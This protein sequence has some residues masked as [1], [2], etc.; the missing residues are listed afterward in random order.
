[1]KTYKYKRQSAHEMDVIITTNNSGDML[2]IYT[3]RN[4]CDDFHV[5]FS[6]NGMTTNFRHIRGECMIITPTIILE[7]ECDDAYNNLGY[8]IGTLR[9]LTG[10]Y[11]FLSFRKFLGFI[12]PDS[13]N[14]SM[15]LYKIDEIGGGKALIE[16]VLIN[17]IVD[18]II[19]VEYKYGWAKYSLCSKDYCITIR[20]Y[21]AVLYVFTDIETFGSSFRSKLEARTKRHVYEKK[22][23]QSN[24]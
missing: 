22:F 13:F 1:M 2:S 6:R 24:I 8:L 21:Q 14:I 16:N 18:D 5:M 20:D 12:I 3:I 11:Y 7:F 9:L 17:G 19:N 4:N 15:K 23:I 10:E